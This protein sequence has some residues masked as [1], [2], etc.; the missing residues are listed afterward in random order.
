MYGWFG[1]QPEARLSQLQIAL[2]FSYLMSEIFEPLRLPVS[3]L[4]APRVSAWWKARRGQPVAPEEAK[5]APGVPG[6]SAGDSE[7]KVAEKTQ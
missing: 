4:F 1:L 7:V 2:F 5:A 3:I 6:P